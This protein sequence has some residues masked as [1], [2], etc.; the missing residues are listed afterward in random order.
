MAIKI[1]DLLREADQ[2]IEKKASANKEAN[3][4][5]NSDETVKLASLLLQEDEVLAKLASSNKPE[6][7]Q[8]EDFSVKLAHAL[9]IGEM[10]NNIEK[11]DKIEEFEKRASAQGFTQEQIDEYIV[12]KML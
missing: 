4:V 9:V 8:E 2:F 11:F 12:E 6:P 1:E 3:L 7:K 10:L 5:E